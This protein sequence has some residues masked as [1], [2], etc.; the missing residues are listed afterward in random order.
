MATKYC[1]FVA[2]AFIFIIG[3]KVDEW[4]QE[5]TQSESRWYFPSLL[6]FIFAAYIHDRW[7]QERV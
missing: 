3:T 7:F 1:K 4:V 6:V 5:L 2:V